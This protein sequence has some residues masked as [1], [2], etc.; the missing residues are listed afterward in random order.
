MNAIIL[1]A[2]RGERLRPHTLTKP[3]CMVELFGKTLLENQLS[4]FRKC[5]IEN[6]CVVTGYKS[7]FIKYKNVDYIKNPD[8]MNTNIVESL[9]TAVDK[10]TESTIVSYGDIV[11]EEKIL[12][13]L[14]HSTHDFSIVIDK[15][16]EKY[17]KIRFDNPLDDVESLKL[18]DDENITSIGRKIT[19]INELE[20]QYIGLMKFQ[21]NAVSKIK[22]FYT[23]S[24]AIFENTH[25][26]PLNSS[27]SFKNSYMTDFLQGLIDDGEK[28]KAITIENGWLELDTLND[29]NLYNS[30]NKLREFY[31]PND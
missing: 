22:A 10:F 23:K 3:K 27:L 18:D 12:N 26:N 19:N 2:G 1:A 25:S 15:K 5:G 11:F 7:K 29:Y 30:K 13:K 24:K 16:W 17:W 8:F 4:V 9:F 21:Y 20:G 14:I 28:L 6:I 31:D